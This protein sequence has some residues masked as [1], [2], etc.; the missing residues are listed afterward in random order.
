LIYIHPRKLPF[1]PFS[2]L[3]KGQR[4]TFNLT[5]IASGSINVSFLIPTT[6]L[7]INIPSLVEVRDSQ[8]VTVTFYAPDSA[9]EKP[10]S[11]TV[12][13]T[14]TNGAKSVFTIEGQIKEALA[15]VLLDEAH[16][17][18]IPQ[19]GN[20]GSSLHY[21]DNSN[22]YGAFREWVA[23]MES[24]QVAVT[25]F[26]GPELNS[27]V[28]KDHDLFVMLNAFSYNYDIFTD[29]IGTENQSYVAFSPN[30]T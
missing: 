15:S 17:I 5:V 11:T 6:N 21:G 8:L 18:I 3:F 27:S 20:T 30:E 13:V 2:T 25:P 4:W 28:L 9:E 22:I 1:E 14:S 24:C 23:L 10:V 16:Q 29:W 12:N 7:Q 26:T 19:P